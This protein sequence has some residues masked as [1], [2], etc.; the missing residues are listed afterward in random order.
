ML[1]PSLSSS[2]SPSCSDYA[3]DSG[4]VDSGSL[5]GSDASSLLLFESSPSSSFPLFP[6]PSS[7]SCGMQGSISTPLLMTSFSFDWSDFPI[8]YQQ[9][10]DD[11]MGFD[12]VAQQQQRH[13]EQVVP[14]SHCPTLR[15]EPRT[16]DEASSV[17]TSSSSS[18]A[19]TNQ[20]DDEEEPIQDSSSQPLTKQQE[21]HQHRHRKTVSW[22]SSLEVRT[23]S[24]ILGDHPCC[25]G[26]LPLQ[27][28]W[29]HDDTQRVDF[30]SYG[31]SSSSSSSFY[32]SSSSRTSHTPPPRLTWMERKNLLKRVSGMSERELN[33]AMMQRLSSLSTT[34]TSSSMLT[35]HEEEHQ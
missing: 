17:S 34:T 9:E 12:L 8:V 19:S 5:F 10:E 18:I 32:L 27:L 25:N 14:V 3:M 20:D 31:T 2:S 6:H 7:S 1:Q 33:D 30:E 11:T 15:T 16:R 21:Q 28:G 4:L 24:V 35:P 26:P 29:E 13:H 23:H 22:G